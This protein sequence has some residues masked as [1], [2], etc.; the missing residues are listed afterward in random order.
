MPAHHKGSE[1]VTYVCGH[2]YSNFKAH[3]PEPGELKFCTKCR[4]YTHRAFPMPKDSAG[5]PVEGE[6]R[7]HCSTVSRCNSG[8][9]HSGA[10][11]E[12]AMMA[13]SKHGRKFP[14]HK[15]WLISPRGIVVAR[16]GG[17]PEPLFD[18]PGEEFPF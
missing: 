8:Q 18:L 3:A 2:T 6:W 7:W 15:V 1:A 5:D 14:H 16:W 12:L 17:E 11:A 9:H 4:V 10:S 13:G